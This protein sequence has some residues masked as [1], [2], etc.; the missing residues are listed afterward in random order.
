MVRRQKSEVAAHPPEYEYSLRRRG[1]TP[2]AVLCML[3]ENKRYQEHLQ[4]GILAKQ[5]RKQHIRVLRWKDNHESFA[6]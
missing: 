6:A 5:L 2:D 3:N 4:R 1:A